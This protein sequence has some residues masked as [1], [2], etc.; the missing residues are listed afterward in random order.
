MAGRYLGALAVAV[1]ALG[2][3]DKPAL[4]GP[5]ACTCQNLESL[6]QEYQNAVFLEGYMQRL[7]AQ[8]K[9]EEERLKGL[10]LSTNTDPDQNLN[11]VATVAQV[12]TAYE[13]ANLHL[14]FPATK[15]YTGPE[16]VPM[17]P[18]T[19]EQA[20]ADL[21]AMEQG[22]PCEAIADMALAHELGHRDICDR[23]GAPAYW[24]RMLSEIALEEAGMY[25][26]QA[27]NLKGE[28][29]RVL[30]ASEITLKGEWRHVISGGDVELTYFYQFQSGDI[31][32]ASKGDTW[33]MAGKGETQNSIESMKIPGVSCTS[34]GAVRNDFEV[35]VTTDG[36]TFGLDYADR[37]TG[38][39]LK[40]ICD[41]GMSMVVPTGE[42]SSGKLASGQPLVAGDNPVPNAWADAMMALAASEGMSISGE[43]K[44]VLSVTCKSP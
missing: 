16:R 6:Q 24:G 35:A 43:P 29:R 25:K 11:I 17:S 33:T 31:G 13:K 7:A 3:A 39:D 34:S 38:G 18:G 32:G 9:A 27:G 42:A 5:P 4:A 20:Q 8:L 14:P 30:E 36:L 44:T 10:K 37:N 15:G 40:L 23:L 2:V 21:D 1:L 26:I 28:L 12:R 22:S 19:C 41:G